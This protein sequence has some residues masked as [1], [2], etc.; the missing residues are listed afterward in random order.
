M[1]IVDA[2]VEEISGK[3]EADF[4]SDDTAKHRRRV[5]FAYQRGIQR[6]LEVA[7]QQPLLA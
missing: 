1:N 6:P 7:I 4:L 2:L 3:V 5:L